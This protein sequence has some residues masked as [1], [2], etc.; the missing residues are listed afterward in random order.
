MP[1]AT[2]KFTGMDNVADPAN[3]GAPDPNSR[4]LIFTEVVRLANVDPTDTGGVSLRPGREASLLTPG[5]H[6]GWS[7]P[8]APKEGYFVNG[9][10]LNRINADGTITTVRFD[11]IPGREVVYCQVNDV[12]VYSNGLQFGIIEDGLDTPPYTPSGAY[13]Q[14]MVAGKHLAYLNG[15]LYALMDNY[16]GKPC[17]LVC[18]DT[19]DTAGWLESMDV[20]ENIVASFDGEG[21]MVARIEAEAG[22]GLFVS[23]TIETFWLGMRDAVLD[24]GF[25]AQ[26]SVAPYPAIPGTVLPIKADLLGIKGL[27]GNCAIWASARGV[28]LGAAGGFFMNLTDE[29]VSYPSGARGAAMLREHRGQVHYVF[30]IQGEDG[31]YNE[32]EAQ[33]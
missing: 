23:S 14:R 8:Y 11:M 24:G 16:L 32:Y 30:A 25:T 13:K 6:S 17:A 12:T 4:A 1:T 3:V 10:L 7:N 2:Y 29:K 15:R 9:T 28:C 20:R 31:A 22:S 5:I 18:S 33:L 21:S 19:L 26:V 27:T